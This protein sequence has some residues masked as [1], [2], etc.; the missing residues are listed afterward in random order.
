MKKGKDITDLLKKKKQFNSKLLRF[1]LKKD[2]L[3][4]EKVV[5]EEIE[6][7]IFIIDKEIEK[8]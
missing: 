2:I 4:T 3:P 1:K 6:R 8:Y 5:I 7:Q